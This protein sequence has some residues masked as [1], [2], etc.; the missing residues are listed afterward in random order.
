MLYN[1]HCHTRGILCI[2]MCTC[3]ARYGYSGTIPGTTQNR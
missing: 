1:M 2:N 3:T